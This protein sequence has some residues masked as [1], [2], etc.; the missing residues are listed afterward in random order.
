MGAVVGVRSRATGPGNG[1]RGASFTASQ[2]AS[3]TPSPSSLFDGD[4]DLPRS[5]WN[6]AWLRVEVV[7]VGRQH[8]EVVVRDFAAI[9]IWA[10]GECRP[11]DMRGSHLPPT[12][13]GVLPPDSWLSGGGATTPFV[14]DAAGATCRVAHRQ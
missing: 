12:A 5:P 1:T 6:L 3:R 9:E 14:A 4:P 2:N 13:G 10:V 7:R 8:L 11:W